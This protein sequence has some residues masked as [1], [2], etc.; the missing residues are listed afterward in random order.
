MTDRGIYVG[1]NNGPSSKKKKKKSEMRSKALGK[2]RREGRGRS[3][4]KVLLVVFSLFL[5]G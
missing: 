5:M 2:R 3:V 1:K 4:G